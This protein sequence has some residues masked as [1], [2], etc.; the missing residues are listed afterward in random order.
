MK[1]FHSTPDFPAWSRRLGPM[2]PRL[3]ATGLRLRQTTLAQLE[4]RLGNCLPGRWLDKPATG[5][6]SRDRIYSLSRTFWGWLWQMLNHNAPCRE[7]VRQMQA[8]C[9]LQG[10]PV[11]DEDTGGYCQARAHLPQPVL[12]KALALSAR[13]ATQRAPAL[14]LLKGRRLKVVDGSSLRLADTPANQKRFPQPPNQ[15]RGCGFPVMKLVVLFCLTSGVLLARATGTLWESEARLLHRL[16]ATLKP[17]DIV[18]GD[19]GFGNFVILALLAGAGMDFIGRVPTNIRHVDLRRGRRL[20]RYD[21]VVCWG[22]GP[23]QGNWLDAADWAALPQQLEVRIVRAQVRQRGF[24]SREITLVTT[25]LDPQLYPAE[26][27]LAAYARRWRLELCLDD[28]KTTLGLETL[29]CLSPAMAEKELLVGLI[30]HNLLRCV[31]AEAA[32]T[33]QLALNRISFK[34]ALDA[35]RQ[36]NHA[37]CQTRCA[38]RKKELWAA[39]LLALASDLVPERPGRR[40]PRAIKRRPKYDLLNRPR[41]QYRDRPRRS[42]RRSRSNLLRLI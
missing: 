1:H 39:L 36:F 16:L 27:L 8:L 18:V 33:H 21:R 6:H 28:L 42:V 40:E 34:G 7:V 13:T 41:A 14:P 4:L 25:L 9:A 10:G 35:L 38:R 26:E 20:G 37:L 5:P 2:K 3:V 32:Q 11:V 23:R 17:G 12:E 15:K 19:R 30:A 24:R 31:M 22:K 29:K